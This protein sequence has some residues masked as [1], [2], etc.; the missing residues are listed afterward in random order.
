MRKTLSVYTAWDTIRQKGSKRYPYRH[1]TV[2]LRQ[3]DVV[4]SPADGTRHTRETIKNL[5]ITEFRRRGYA[6]VASDF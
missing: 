3:D 4:P 2:A 6:I 1:L 5:I